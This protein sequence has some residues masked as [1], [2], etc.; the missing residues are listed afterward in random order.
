MENSCVL[1]AVLK[2]SAELGRPLSPATVSRLVYITSRYKG[3]PY[4]KLD[5]LFDLLAKDLGA[6]I[7]V[8]SKG[9][10]DVAAGM[11]VIAMYGTG[12]GDHAEFGYVPFAC[13]EK[14]TALFVFKPRR[15]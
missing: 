1:R 15:G 6:F 13:K 2:A 14:V 11:P 10:T 3:W 7:L 12:N 5:E 9:L 8:Q 4:G